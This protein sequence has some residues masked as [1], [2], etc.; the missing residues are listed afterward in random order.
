MAEDK[1]TLGQAYIQIMPT[2]DGIKSQ[3]E[4]ALGGVSDAAGR[5]AGVGF[6]SSFGDVLKANLVTEGLK[7]ALDGTKK[8]GEAVVGVAQ[9][10]VDSYANYEQLVGGVETLFKGSADQVQ[11]YAGQ[12]YKT[13]G[14][15][16]NQY[17]ETV[18]SFSASLLQSL[19]G[20]TKAAA[21]MADLAITDMAD[22]ANKMGS[23]MTSIQNAYQGFA[24][25]NYSMLDNLKLGYGGTQTEMYRLLQDAAALNEEFANTANF[26]MDSKGHLEAGYADIVQAIHIVQTEMDITGTTAK[27]AEHTISGSLASMRSAWENLLVGIADENA[28]FDVLVQNFVDS[29]VAAGDNLIPRIEQVL[30]G[31][32]K[33]VEGLAP[34]IIERLPELVESV[35]PPLASAALAMVEAFGSTIIDNGPRLFEAG[36]DLIR[37]LSEGVAENLP[38]LLNNAL[39]ML[40]EFSGALREGAGKLVDE[41]L[42]FLVQLARGIADGL[43][44]FIENI[45]QIVTNIANIINDNAPKILIAGVEIVGTLIVGIIKSIP[46]L[47][48]SIPQI[49]E[50]IFAVIQ[51]VNWINLGGHIVTGIRDGINWFAGNAVDAINSLIDNI[52][53]FFS[54]AADDAAYWGKDLIYSFID[55]I[56]SAARYLW[57]TM[58]DIARGIWSYIHFSEPEAGPLSDFSTY[59]PDMMR[60]F[61][62]GMRENE[63]LV[64]SQMERS[65]ALPEQNNMKYQPASMPTRLVGV[66]ESALRSLSASSRGYTNQPVTLVMEVDRTQFARL[67]YQLGREETQRVGVQ[68]ATGGA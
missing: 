27:E 56:V 4:D 58:E 48:A 59:A 55:G 49:V 62:Q 65:F 30:N 38:V 17:M 23:D 9:Q 44:A 19:G 33:L 57:S 51:A 67:V 28:N 41:G 13:A 61:A 34:A 2:T 15:S 40:V 21:G 50:A 46:T 3:L 22:N 7:M 68:L 52:F 18:T 14:L 47:V 37:S 24:K 39:P 26:S 36:L 54:G 11:Q 63:G 6:S 12:A 60:L 31:I 42:N 32:G 64:R 16:A 66:N 8:L 20:D 53:D 29:A 43:P 5:S 10:A 45:P 35:V 25:Q 1:K